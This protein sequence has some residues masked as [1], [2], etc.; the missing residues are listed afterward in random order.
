MQFAVFSTPGQNCIVK[1]ERKKDD[2]RV[3]SVYKS[4]HTLVIR[5]FWPGPK[6][7]TLY[8]VLVRLASTLNKTK[9]KRIL[10]QSDWTA[11]MMCIL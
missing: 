7:K 8:L 10:S 11:L 5:F 2:K 4:V 1:S 9:D 6:K 3:E